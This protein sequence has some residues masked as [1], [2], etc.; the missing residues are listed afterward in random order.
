HKQLVTSNNT[1]DF[2]LGRG[3]H[4]L[5]AIG[6]AANRCVLE[7]QTRSQDCQLS[8]TVFNQVTRAQVVNGQPCLWR[9]TRHGLAAGEA[10]CLFVLLPEGFRNAALHAH[11]A[12]LMGESP[13]RYPPGRMTYD[14]RR[15]RL[16]DCCNAFRAPT[17]TT[18]PP[19]ASA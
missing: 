1:R 18:S 8:E 17:A 2:G 5:R 15:L 7:V 12:V 13:E 11:V 9:C 19:W 3:L 4:N 10:L 14:L 6:L 16:M